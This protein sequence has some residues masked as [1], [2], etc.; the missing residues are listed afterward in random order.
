MWQGL[1]H[2]V[3][4]AEKNTAVEGI[5]QHATP[6]QDFFLML[7][8]SVSMAAFGLLLNNMVILV[9]SMLI[10]P[11]LYPI[12]SFALGVIV[13]DDKLIG[14]SFYT[15][16]KSVVYALAAAF[17]I[18]FFFSAHDT[19]VI[20]PFTIAGSPAS[21][22]MYAVVAAIAGFA[23]AFAMTKPY[24]NESLPG[25]AIS[26]ALVP[27]LAEAGV[28]LSS[29]DWALFSSS[30]L[31]FLVNIIGIVFSAMIVFALLRF[32]VKKTVAE[33][34]IKEEDKVIKKE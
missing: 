14:R 1:F 29:F 32:S 10:A 26:V 33:V 3:S 16:L 24:L 23:G 12:L 19:S 28:A 22:L 21:S 27:P 6:R 34:A 18:G 13:A 11:L 17:I 25:V 20:V 5:I 7:I 4:E 2:N 31:L 9:G 15:L 8:L 30:L